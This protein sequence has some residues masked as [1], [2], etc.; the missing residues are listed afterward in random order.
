M[1][2]L[3]L[4]PGLLPAPSTVLIPYPDIRASLLPVYN[5]SVLSSI[6]SVIYSREV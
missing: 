1:G 4:K 6:L 5:L 3:R 2:F